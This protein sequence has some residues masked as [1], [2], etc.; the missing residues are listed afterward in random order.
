[1]TVTM[2][3]SYCMKMGAAPLIMA[4]LQISN[5]LGSHHAF[6]WKNRTLTGVP[7]SSIPDLTHFF[8]KR[9]KEPL[10]F[11]ARII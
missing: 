7:S 3:T 1:M 10:V 6:Y 8:Y 9:R 4:V 11:L 2:E 5:L